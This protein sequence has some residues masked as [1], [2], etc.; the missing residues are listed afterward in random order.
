MRGSIGAT[1]FTMRSAPLE[2]QLELKCDKLAYLA[3]SGALVATNVEVVN[4]LGNTI[5]ASPDTPLNDDDGTTM[6]SADTFVAITNGLPVVKVERDPF[7]GAGL[8]PDELEP[9]EDFTSVDQTSTKRAAKMK[10]M[11]N[12]R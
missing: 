7:S 4:P 1:V 12:D 9:E 3:S 2:G 11:R 6:L 8:P 10:T 5:I